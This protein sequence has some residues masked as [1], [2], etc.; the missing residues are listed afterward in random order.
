M[1][2]FKVADGEKVL[3][4]GDSITDAA[5]RGDF[6]PYGQGYVSKA[7]QLV[8]AKYPE[9]RILYVNTGIGG[10]TVRD[11]R[12]RWQE[13]VVAHQPDWLSVMVGINDVHRFINSIPENKIDVLEYE[14]T[15]RRMLT[16]AREKTSAR[17]ILMEPFY[18]ST[19]PEH[20]SMRTL[21]EYL[22]VVHRLAEEFD[23]LLVPVHQDFQKALAV[24]PASEWSED[25]VHPFPEGHMLIALS[26]L[27]VMG[28]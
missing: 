16:T 17:L 26:W 1:G 3:F 14:D 23:A 9:R 21:T 28:W 8:T 25:N 2:E 24:R 6:A 11:L 19:D 18:L 10:N 4:T 27:R 20:V 22:E 13:D 5:R 7:I 12:P 15:Y